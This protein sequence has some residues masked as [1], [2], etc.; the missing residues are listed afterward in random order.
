[1]ARRMRVQLRHRTAKLSEQFGYDYAVRLFGQEAIDSIPTLASGP[2]KGKPKGYLTWRT[3]MSAGWVAECQGA[4]KEGGIVDAWIG[5]GMGTYRDDA[6][7]GMWCGRNQSLAGSRSTLT[8]EYREFAA[9]DQVRHNAEMAELR[10]RIAL[11]G[12]PRPQ[13]RHLGIMPHLITS[14]KFAI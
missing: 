12:V 14:R 13:F 1:M 10:A 4:C 5:E 11:G 2:N 3:A 6:M 8:R 9:R 7:R